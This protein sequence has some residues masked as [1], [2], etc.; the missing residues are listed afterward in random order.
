MAMR[1]KRA[2][3]ETL[4]HF[5]ALVAETHDELGHAEAGI[6]LHDVPEDGT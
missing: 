4:A 5:E 6:Q 3:G 1:P 2:G